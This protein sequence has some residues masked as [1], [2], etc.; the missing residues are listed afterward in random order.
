MSQLNNYQY[1]SLVGDE[2]N[3][4]GK[5]ITGFRQGKK[6]IGGYSDNKRTGGKT[7]SRSTGATDKADEMTLIEEDIR[8]A[9]RDIAEGTDLLAGNETKTKDTQN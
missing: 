4:K 6:I 8:K 5:K 9:E 1:A 3:E 7:E 2:D